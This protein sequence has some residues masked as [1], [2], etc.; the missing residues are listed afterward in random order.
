MKLVN[1]IAEIK[2]RLGRGVGL[3]S[4]IKNMLY[5]TTALKLLLNLEI[6]TAICLAPCVLIGFYIIG[7]LDLDRFK[8]AQEEARLNTGK[9][10]PY[11]KKKLG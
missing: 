8:L 9:Y 6:F 2:I 5:V 3:V 4:E 10:N 1:R 11:F 7:A